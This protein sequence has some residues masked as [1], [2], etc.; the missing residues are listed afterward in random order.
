MVAGR[1][2]SGQFPRLCRNDPRWVATAVDDGCYA[3]A[4]GE[5]RVVHGEVGDRVRERL[6]GLFAQ[7]DVVGLE[8]QDE[9][10]DRRGRCRG[11][12]GLASD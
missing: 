4:G 7:Q 3:D 2:F 5:D 10:P 1:G 12:V 6:V 11:G 8:R 9:Q